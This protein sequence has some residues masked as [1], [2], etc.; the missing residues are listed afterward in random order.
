MKVRLRPAFVLW[1]RWFGLLAAVWLILMAVTGSIIVYYDELDVLLNPDTRT[2]SEYS[3]GHLPLGEIL[4]SV[5][6]SVP[7]TYAG[8]VDFSNQP[9]DAYRVLLRAKENIT[10]PA[11]I[12]LEIFVN[13]YTG[14][15]LGSRDFGSIQFDRNHIMGLIYQLHIDLL[16]GPP[17]YG[18]LA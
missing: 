13:P 4:S 14:E 16:L 2:V 18:F 8:Y 15:V 17:W 6:K 11:S 7:G 1:H 9:T 10:L 12:N 3:E 5:E